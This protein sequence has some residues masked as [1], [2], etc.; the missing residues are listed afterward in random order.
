MEDLTVNSDLNKDVHAEI[1]SDTSTDL[2]TPPQ[3]TVDAL[4]SAMKIDEETT[5][6]TGPFQTID[7]VPDFRNITFQ[8]VDHSIKI[9]EQLSQLK[10]A[11]ITP[12]SILAYFL[13]SIYTYGTVIDIYAV[14]ES[15]SH[16]GSKY[17]DKELCQQYTYLSKYN[18][19]P[20][21]L[22]DI[23]RGLQHTLDPRRKN[24]A[25]MF[26]FAAFSFD[27]DFGR[28]YPI[29]M[30]L[31]LHD[32]LAEYPNQS[33]DFIWQLWLDTTLITHD[34]NIVKVANVIGGAYN[35]NIVNNYMTT[36]LRKLLLPVLMNATTHRNV[37]TTFDIPSTTQQIPLAN[38]NP[39]F[40]LQSTYAPQLTGM[41]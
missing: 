39:Y 8:L 4:F 9:Y 15:T 27:H 10:L 5:T 14:R 21:F 1:T 20:P 38:T 2:N 24:L 33:V 3:P 31:I 19:I 16:Y 32:L 12:P 30:F 29:H 40:Y 34:N 11:F 18:I 37:Y 23:I 35:N 26:S 13:S 25:Y 28:I 41:I 17:L 36:Q 6:S 7:V 22:K